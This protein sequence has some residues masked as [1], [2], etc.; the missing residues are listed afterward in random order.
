MT[1][2]HT[3]RKQMTLKG[4][5][6]VRGRKDN[7]ASQVCVPW[8]RCKWFIWL[9]SDIDNPAGEQ[10]VSFGTSVLLAPKTFA[11]ARDPRTCYRI[12]DWLATVIVFII[13][14]LIISQEI[15]R[16]WKNSTPRRNQ[17]SFKLL[18]YNRGFVSI[19][20]ARLFVA[21]MRGSWCRALIHKTLNEKA[22]NP[23]P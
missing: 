4:H 15:D 1:T 16:D 10:L 19:N 17:D 8:R 11:L 20:P 5:S 14:W 3:S 7:E 9:H 23:E 21:I 22:I 13:Y 2:G 18:Q 12:Q 6:L